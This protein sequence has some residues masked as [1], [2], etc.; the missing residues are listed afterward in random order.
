MKVIISE[1][2]NFRELN[3]NIKTIRANYGEVFLNY[4]NNDGV[5]I[6]INPNPDTCIYNREELQADFAIETIASTNRGAGLAI[7]EL[8]N[9]LNFADR[10]DYSVS[11]N[12]D[13]Q[14]ATTNALGEKELEIGLSDEQLKQWYLRHGF[15]FEKGYSCGYRPKKSQKDNFKIDT[16]SMKIDEIDVDRIE[17]ISDPE[18]LS[19]LLS[20]GEL[21]E[22]QIYEDGDSTLYL[23]K[24]GKPKKP[25]VFNSLNDWEVWFQRNFLTN[26]DRL[27]E[28]EKV[29][30]IRAEMLKLGYDGIVIVGREMVNYTPE[31]VMYFSNETQ[32]E[33]Y[34]FSKIQNQ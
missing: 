20:M 18:T 31:D 26:Y 19:N 12:V 8:Q 5:E 1:S 25:K 15:L 29:T 4:I 23:F 27:S 28:F 3:P 17:S 7:K 13:S 6:S 9:I 16:I 32:L 21:E 33:N 34:F 22:G 14:G 24:N 30:S 10:H 11:L 2:I